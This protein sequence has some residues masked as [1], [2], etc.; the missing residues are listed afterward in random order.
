VKIL[1]HNSPQGA[2]EI[3]GVPGQIEPGEPFKVDDEQAGPLLEQTE[4]YH[5]ASKA[6][7][8]AHADAQKAVEK[9]EAAAEAESTEG[10]S[11]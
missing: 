11:A 7:L 3:V 5:V 2:L 9:V 10:D 6:E 4:L 1:I 8:K